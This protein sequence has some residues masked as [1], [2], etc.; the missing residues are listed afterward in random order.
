M[1]AYSRSTVV[2]EKPEAVATL[3]IANSRMKD[4]FDFGFDGIVLSSG[5]SMTSAANALGNCNVSTVPLPPGIWLLGT[6][7]IVMA[8]RLGQ[9]RRSR[10]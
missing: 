4:F 6:G 10:A 9:G 1:R 7:L 8:G 5:V 2:A 3:G